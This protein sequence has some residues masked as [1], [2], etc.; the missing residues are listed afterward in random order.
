MANKL[1]LENV[2]FLNENELDLI[3]NE[4]YNIGLMINLN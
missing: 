4:N 2:Q 3:M 1:C